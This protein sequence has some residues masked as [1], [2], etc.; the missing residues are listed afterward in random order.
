[1]CRECQEISQ[2]HLQQVNI[3][4][5]SANSCFYVKFLD[6]NVLDLLLYSINSNF[7]LRIDSKLLIE[8]N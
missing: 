4:L 2:T 6:K 8:G 5:L 1:M 7:G 3:I